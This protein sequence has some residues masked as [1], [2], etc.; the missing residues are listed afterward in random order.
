MK[1]LF[2][3]V[4]IAM[5][6]AVGVAGVAVA[7]TVPPP[8]QGLPT[9]GVP[10]TGAALLDRIA[11]IGNWVF[12]IFLAIS[13]IYIILGAFQFV[14]GGGDPAQVSAARQKLLYAAVGIAI[15]LLAAGFDDILRNILVG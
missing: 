7:Q 4:A 11:I 10:T 5:F 2:I 14:T 8:G 9:T 15:A 12:A 6:L 3:V 1:K 13:I